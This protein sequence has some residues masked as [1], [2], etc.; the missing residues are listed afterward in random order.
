MG[1][2]RTPSVLIAITAAAALS[3]CGHAAKSSRQAA[4]ARRPATSAANPGAFHTVKA[5]ETLYRI[6]G[7][8]GVAVEALVAENGLTDPAALEV[9]Q[10][11]FVPGAT[12][13]VEVPK[14]SASGRP[15]GPEQA[16]A[17]LQPVLPEKS[18]V[19]KR[20]VEPRPQARQAAVS[21]PRAAGALAWPVHGVIFSPFGSR[22]RDQHDGI[23]LAAPEGTP[24]VAAESGT[25]LFVGT[26]RGYGNLI[27]VG[28]DGDVVTVYA[29]NR[30]N[31]VVA[32]QRVK[33]GALIA[34]VG[35]TG[36]ATGPHLH[37]EV[38]IAARPRDPLA[39]L[40]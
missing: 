39:F 27:L 18:A 14:A 38:R 4:T 11:L 26:K 25:V 15:A 3:A 19:A 35:R 12:E 40:R 29:H 30:E 34:R 5:G 2:A 21:R 17:A 37:F 7:A 23:D 32:G 31:L 36:N 8:Y 22:A 10:R 24:V 28:H 20:P 16:E 9:G 6:A 13:E 33:R 1:P